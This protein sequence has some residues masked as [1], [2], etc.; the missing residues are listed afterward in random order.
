MA[1]ALLS[2]YK[3]GG[4]VIDRVTAAAPEA[5]PEAEPLPLAPLPP[6][7]AGSA[8]LEQGD[9]PESKAAGGTSKA[10][11]TTTG[12]LGCERD[13]LFHQFTIGEMSYRVGGVRQLFVT[14]L[15]VN[16][17]ASSGGASY[18]DSLDL[19]AAKAR[20]GYAQALARSFGVELARAEKDLVLILEYLE[21]ERDEA[22]R[23]GNEKEPVAVSAQDRGLALE[24]LRD[25]RLFE[26]IAEDLS[27]L[28]YVG[29]DLNKELV[30]LCASSR[31]LDDPISVLILSQS[32]AGKSYLVEMV[33]RLM[34]PEEVVAVTSL[35]DQAL[36]YIDDLS[37]KF[38]I[39]G[40]AVHGEVV[41]HQ[42]R[43][44]LSGK[45]LSRLVTVKD[46]ETGK[47]QSRVVR[48]PVIV[49]S[50][51]SGTSHAL[52]PEN[53]SRYFVVNADESREQTERIHEA[54]RQKYSLARL[55]HGQGE[56]ER[57]IR[58]HQAAQR[59]LVKK[60]IVNDFAPLLGFPTS[61]MRSRRDHDRFL[62]LIAC[63][64]YLRQYQKREEHEG[65]LSFICCDLEDYAVAYRIMVEGVLSSTVR[66]LPAG[67]V[68][69]YS[70]L[71]T[72]VG[73][74]AERQGL[75][76]EEVSFTQRQVREFT[77]L[78]HTWIKQA[79]R[80]L[81]EYEYLSIARGGSERTRA[82]YRIR[83]DAAIAEMD[84]SMIPSPEAMAEKIKLGKLVK[85]GH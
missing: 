28:G 16:I 62:D 44:M 60:P 52:N 69:L 1:K 40:E 58:T 43:E 79:L 50:V 54:Q 53:V 71:R 67:A 21:R 76:A 77:G 27:A 14:S 57:I 61:L 10:A 20:T 31:R 65:S 39:L 59:L 13:G 68:G 5:A 45:E 41:E 29:E 49:S 47:M 3:I 48:T 11:A 32:A 66:E 4:D 70:E 56:V 64:C 82:F 24:L 81:V 35:S 84:L 80:Q 33:R 37:H 34:P 46:P 72:W 19:Y 9:S 26:R 2:E 83:E 55:E 17:R 6:H 74:E 75:R 25:P 8:A 23:R 51:M 36:N 7:S 42:I 30:Y 22:L 63:V 85:S 73:R 38:L 18:Y 12:E 78:G 15:K